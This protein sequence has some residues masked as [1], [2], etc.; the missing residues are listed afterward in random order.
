V[1]DIS[2]T[3]DI[4]AGFPG[5]T[6]EDHHLTIQALQQLR[7]D[8]A[9]IYKYSMRPGTPAAKLAD[10]VLLAV[11]E[12]RNQELLDVQRQISGKNH[13]VWLGREVRLFLERRSVRNPD[14]VIGRTD[15]DHNVIIQDPDAKLGVFDQVRLQSLERETFIGKKILTTAL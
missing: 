2:I 11:K 9:Y 5:E 12:Q 1:P 8:S 10:D 7:F 4:I 6:T 13:R 15:Q 3:T 14:Q